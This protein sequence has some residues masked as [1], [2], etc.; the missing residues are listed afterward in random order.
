MS[1]FFVRDVVALRQAMGELRTNDTARI[2]VRNVLLNLLD[3]ET[4]QRGYLLTAD[5]DYLAPYLA[6]RTRVRE[7]LRLAEQSGYRD[8]QFLGNVRRLSQVTESKLEEL[9][10]TIALTRRGDGVRAANIVREGF[11]RARMLEARQLIFGEVTRLRLVRERTLEAF[12]DR[13]LRAAVTLVL[14]LSTVIAMAA[15]AWR[16]LSAAARRN[17]E[18]AKHLALEASHDVLTGLPNRR[19]FERW[20]RRL[21]AESLRSGKSFT[22]LAIDLDRF[23]GVN[24]THGHGVGDEVLKEV[25]NRFQALLRSGEFLARLGGDEFVVLME[26]AFSHDEIAS[27]GQ[28]LIDVLPPSLHPQLARHAVGA[29]VGAASFPQDGTELECLMQAADEALYVS[30]R[31]G[32]GILSFARGAPTTPCAGGSAPLDDLPVF[33]R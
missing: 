3:A 6:G 1:I 26:G 12:N 17:N 28:R 32:R 29:S 31:G 23:K 22:L 27:I 13:L 21:A 25:A 18:L 5:P 15:S 30:K 33:V 19:F 4:G 16:S 14:I 2:Q 7:S 11:G 24:D 20:A 8:P 10:R 9:E